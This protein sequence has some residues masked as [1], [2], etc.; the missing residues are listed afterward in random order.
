M[1]SKTLGSGTFGKVKLAYHQITKH[2]VAVKI[3]SRSKI[4]HLDVVQ[5]IKR[6]IKN[7]QLVRHPHIIKLY[8]AISSPTEFYRVL[9]SQWHTLT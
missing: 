5:K 7:L 2:K 8:Q 4:K 6:E 9:A 3:L 1:L